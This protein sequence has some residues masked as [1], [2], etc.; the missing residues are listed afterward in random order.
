MCISVEDTRGKFRIYITVLNVKSIYFKLLNVI[1][2]NWICNENICHYISS[3]LKR[4]HTWNTL[5]VLNNTCNRKRCARCFYWIQRRKFSCQR[6]R[7]SARCDVVELGMDLFGGKP[8]EHLYRRIVANSMFY[9]MKINTHFDF[10]ASVFS[11]TSA[12]FSSDIST[13]QTMC[14][15][16]AI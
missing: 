13:P 8:A 11:Q 12:P 16:L 9:Y 14:V 7:Q 10:I 5:C 1:K 6:M 15:T 3:R 4:R 2:K